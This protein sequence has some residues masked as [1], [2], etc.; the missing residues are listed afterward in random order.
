[1]LR[2]CVAAEGRW[3]EGSGEVLLRGV[4]VAGRRVGV[5]VRRAAKRRGGKMEMG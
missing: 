5:E 2:T 1:M 3:V 4:T